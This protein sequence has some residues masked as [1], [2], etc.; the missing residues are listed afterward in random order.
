MADCT[1]AVNLTVSVTEPNGSPTITGQLTKDTLI[2]YC[3]KHDAV[4]DLITAL[5]DI[6]Q[7]AEWG[8]AGEDAGARLDKIKD[9]AQDAI[10]K[11]EIPP[12]AG[13]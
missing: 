4:D 10:R 6:E 9:I 5:H 3:P 7:A 1:C 8:L 13:G 12:G 11:A 2:T